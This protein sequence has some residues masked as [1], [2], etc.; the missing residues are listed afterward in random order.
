MSDGTYICSGPSKLKPK[1][2]K[3][4]KTVIKRTSI[5]EFLFERT[6]CLLRLGLAIFNDK[7]S[8]LQAELRMERK[9]QAP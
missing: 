2:K 1:I 6:L 5:G 8:E 9:Q 7:I 4:P 3:I